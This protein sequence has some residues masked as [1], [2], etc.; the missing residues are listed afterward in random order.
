MTIPR[1]NVS[2]TICRPN[3]METPE[4]ACQARFRRASCAG[5]REVSLRNILLV[6]ADSRGH[7]E[8]RICAI[9]QAVS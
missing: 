8:G 4:E 9:I 1:F 5:T 7:V 6:R 3:L 2:G